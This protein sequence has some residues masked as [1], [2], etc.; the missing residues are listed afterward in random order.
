MPSFFPLSLPSCWKKTAIRDPN[1]ADAMLTLTMNPRAKELLE[2]ARLLSDEERTELG[3][4]ILAS[5][6]AQ[7]EEV[8]QAWANECMRRLED[9]RAGR[10][11][12]VPA[13]VAV[14][15]VRARAAARARA[16]V[17]E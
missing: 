15:D 4:E 12:T 16:R 6:P 2:Q 14:A 10:A 11:K 8:E 3:H 17:S 9:V 7:Q 5:V 1:E 13:E